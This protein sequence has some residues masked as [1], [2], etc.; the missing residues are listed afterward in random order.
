MKNK[1]K[2]FW[3]VVFV[4]SII[5]LYLTLNQIIFIAWQSAFTYANIPR[6]KYMINIAYWVAFLLILV[7]YYSFKKVRKKDI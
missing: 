7:A 1:R 3:W 5:L 6:L 4:L 2:I